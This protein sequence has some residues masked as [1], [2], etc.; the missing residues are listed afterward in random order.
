MH[1]VRALSLLL[2]ILFCA[3]IGAQNAIRAFRKLSAPEKR[4][5]CFHPFVA[6]RAYGITKIV[7]TETNTAAHDP[8][9]DTLVNG[10]K[11]D[12]FRHC[13]WMAMLSAKIGTQKA[14]HLGQAHERGNYRQ[15]LHGKTEEG[16]LPDSVSGLMD[17]FNNQRGLELRK[18][19]PNDDL[20]AMREHV[21]QEIEAGHLLIISRDAHGN[22]LTADRTRIDLQKW[23]R[24]WNIPKCLVPSAP[25][26]P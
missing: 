3:R 17:L 21:I 26:P 12:A 20:A 23:Q 15:F 19:F 18:V 16:A 13:F 10:G 25:G 5:V 24:R 22:Y 7:L 11:L 9:L 6:K 1:K 2:L 4:W 8:R 14:S